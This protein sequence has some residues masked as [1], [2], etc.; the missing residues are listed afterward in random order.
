MDDFKC[1]N[2]RCSRAAPCPGCERTDNL[3]TDFIRIL[4][5]TLEE[6][7]AEIQD[8]T[9]Q[10]N[11]ATATAQERYLRRISGVVT[12]NSGIV[13][14]LRAFSAW[15]QYMTENLL[16]TALMRKLEK[17]ESK[18]KEERK[19]RSEKQKKRISALEADCEE[20]NV[21]LQ[22][23]RDLH[24]NSMERKCMLAE[25]EVERLQKR[26]EMEM[27]ER[28]MLLQSL[29]QNRP[30]NDVAAKAMLRYEFEH[31]VRKAEDL[32]KEYK[33]MSADLEVE[34]ERVSV[35]LKEQSSAM[36]N[37]LREEMAELKLQSDAGARLSEEQSAELARGSI[38]ELRATVTDLETRL[39]DRES[40]LATYER[41]VTRKVNSVAKRW[42]EQ[43]VLFH[44][45]QRESTETIRDLR[46]SLKKTESEH[47]KRA[48]QI[49]E[50]ERIRS[51]Q[52]IKAQQYALSEQAK[53]VELE[54]MVI[55]LRTQWSTENG[56]LREEVLSTTDH[57]A[58]TQH[59]VEEFRT[60]TTELRAT[61][62]TLRDACAKEWDKGE[63]LNL[64]LASKEEALQQKQRDLDLVHV[65]VEQYVRA[66]DAKMN[67]KQEIYDTLS[68]A[69]KERVSILKQEKER[70]SK[71]LNER[72]VR[73]E[74]VRK[75][76]KQESIQMEEVSEMRAHVSAREKE[77]HKM[78][79]HENKRDSFF[80][81]YQDEM[82]R[83]V[84]QLE[85]DAE[86][87]ARFLDNYKDSVRESLSEMNQ[88]STAHLDNVQ[89]DTDVLRDEL[90]Q[91]RQQ[92][93]ESERRWEDRVKC[94]EVEEGIQ[95]S[96]WQDY[97]SQMN[98][99]MVRMEDTMSQRDEELRKSKMLGDKKFLQH[100][101]IDDAGSPRSHHA[102]RPRRGRDVDKKHSGHREHGDGKRFPHGKGVDRKHLDHGK[103]VD[104][105]YM[106]HRK[107][108]NGKHTGHGRGVNGK[109]TDQPTQMADISDM[110]AELRE[111][112]AKAR[113]EFE[114]ETN[115]RRRSLENSRMERVENQLQ[116]RALNRER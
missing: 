116:K 82:T 110:V 104:R 53:A 15:R 67:S 20:A 17:S 28:K 88:Q 23:S 84:Q 61:L 68:A 105:K 48:A 66:L 113:A 3:H 33:R 74:E 92:Q 79:E 18:W 46:H 5:E 51:E 47:G 83:K 21:V 56:E 72:S 14:L 40:E 8:L 108:V 63:Q 19:K 78:K 38:I 112:Q 98:N 99:K 37:K 24:D 107:S 102:W 91:A 77:V 86:K 80:K 44:G 43:R 1:T 30:K 85:M 95:T 103:C 26:C 109:H 11:E 94:I 111:K 50:D 9:R 90:S 13:P 58:H 57:C 64:A 65:E 76:K 54:D 69:T 29:A 6:N 49:E 45:F 27:E 41:N 10:H 60:E 81:F 106:D 2:P 35:N 97:I 100:P 96:R 52:K 4:E 73:D 75:M 39:A 87:N 12:R 22:R 89:R 16:R 42:S 93:R 31:E 62:E 115:S 59:E 32:E 71:L 7:D 70:L 101:D 25:M 34:Y 55:R 114:D 36:E